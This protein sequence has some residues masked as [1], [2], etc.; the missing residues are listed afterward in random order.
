MTTMPPQMMSGG[1]IV[2]MNTGGF[3]DE[4][5]VKAPNLSDQKLEELI[6]DGGRCRWGSLLMT[7]P[8]LALR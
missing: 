7:F 1:G 3:L 5:L 8:A 4:V 6:I 2:R